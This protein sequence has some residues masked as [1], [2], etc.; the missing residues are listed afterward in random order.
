MT[1]LKITIEL[2]GTG[3][4]LMLVW[5]AVMMTTPKK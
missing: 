3:L 5:V 4:V 2:M 1:P